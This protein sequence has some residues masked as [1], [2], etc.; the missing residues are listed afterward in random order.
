MLHVAT[1]LGLRHVG[2]N[3][4]TG[5]ICIRG[6]IVK[7]RFEDVQAF[8]ESVVKNRRAYLRADKEAATERISQRNTE[9]SKI[10]TR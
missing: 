8:H 9:K 7:K 5:Y 4:G 1:H 3:L 6:R 2:E 10:D